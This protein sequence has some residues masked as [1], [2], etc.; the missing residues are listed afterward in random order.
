MD[1]NDNKL[2]RMEETT[3]KMMDSLNRLADVLAEIAIEQ[4]EHEKYKIE[5]EAKKESASTDDT[6][7]PEENP[8]E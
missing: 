4:L 6:D 3:Q 1:D 8:E 5:Q 7:K 2:E